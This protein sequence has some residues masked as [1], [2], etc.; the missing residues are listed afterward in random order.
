M[1][2]LSGLCQIN[3]YEG[4]A[5]IKLESAANAS[6]CEL[7]YP[8]Q[9][10]K[11]TSVIMDWQ[12]TIEAIIK[13]YSQGNQTLIAAKFHNTLAEM[14]LNIAQYANQSNIVMSG[15]CFQN[16]YLVERIKQR[17]QDAGFNVFQ[18]EK[19]PPNDGGLALGQL[20][21]STFL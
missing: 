12:P 14:V 15:G 6:S 9:L 7:S 18:H 16:A 19:V 2:S 13:D 4:E 8:Y 3:S 11:N 20:I 10:N 17:L 5:A 1:A 21:A